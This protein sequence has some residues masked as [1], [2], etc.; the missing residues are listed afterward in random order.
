[1]SEFTESKWLIKIGHVFEHVL[2]LIDEFRLMHNPINGTLH[3]LVYL[4]Y[5]YV[6]R[7]PSKFHDVFPIRLRANIAGGRRRVRTNR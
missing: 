5:M 1:M 4:I 2:F 6:N 3:L 7:V